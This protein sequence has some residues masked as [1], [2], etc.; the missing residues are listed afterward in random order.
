VVTQ[1]LIPS[2]NASTD[3]VLH[4]GVKSIAVTALYRAGVDVD[5]IPLT[6][7]PVGY[8]YR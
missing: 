4:H 2:E 6:D 7:G 5:L 8:A 3:Q 1:R